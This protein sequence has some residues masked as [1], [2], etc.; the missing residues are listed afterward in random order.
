MLQKAVAFLKQKEGFTPVAMWDVNAW[1][2]GYGSDTI[3][4]ALGNVRKVVQTDRV[5][6]ADADRDLQRRIEK[7]FIPRI[8]RKIGADAWNKYGDN[9]K[10]A[11][12]SFAY[13]YGDIVKKQIVDA[14]QTGDR[15]KLAD[16]WISSTYNDNKR[17]PENVRNALRKRRATEAALIL[18]DVNGTGAAQPTKIGIFVPMILA[19]T[20][21]YL[22]IK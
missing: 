2:I 5:T 11:F 19:G 7:E 16:A 1:R 17:L 9:T 18:S 20:I 14:A 12:I 13:N 8:I 22:L 15:K 10:I 6:V 21:T 3:T 4:D